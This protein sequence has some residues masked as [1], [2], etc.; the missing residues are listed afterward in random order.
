LLQTHGHGVTGSQKPTTEYDRKRGGHIGHHW[1]IP[2]VA[3]KRAFGQ[4]GMADGGKPEEAELRA[5]A[6]G[7]QPGIARLLMIQI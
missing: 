7:G 5:N 3:R 2:G 1:Q 4:E 6:L